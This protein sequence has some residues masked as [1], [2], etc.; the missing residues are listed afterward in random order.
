M[1]EEASSVL[2]SHTPQNWAMKS[3]DDQGLL[4]QGH[5]SGLLEDK[6]I[7]VNTVDT[8]I[9]NSVIYYYSYKICTLF[10]SV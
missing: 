8:V 6:D 4:Q 7:M 1:V 10:T 3:P 9:T 2:V 5:C